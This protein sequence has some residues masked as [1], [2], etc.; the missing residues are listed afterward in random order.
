MDQKKYMA[1]LYIW[2]CRGLDK[3]LHGGPYVVY[4]YLIYLNTMPTCFLFEE[5]EK[6]KLSIWMW[7]H[8]LPIKCWT[9]KGLLSK[10]TSRVDKPFY[11]DQLMKARDH[12]NF[13]KVLVKVGI[14]KELLCHVPTILPNRIEIDLPIK[15]EHF[16][17]FHTIYR[18]F[19]HNTSTH[20]EEGQ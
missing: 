1:S 12:I 6:N 17:K 10:I 11:T 3:V 14:S 9:T 15:F 4:G 19:K 20:N 18:Q 13:A 2:Q 7:I 5:E 16:L 8:K